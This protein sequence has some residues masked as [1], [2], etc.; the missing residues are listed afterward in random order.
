MSTGKQTTAA[1]KWWLLMRLLPRRG[2][3]GQFPPC[4][5]GLELLL[6]QFAGRAHICRLKCLCCV[7]KA[8]HRGLAKN[9]TRSFVALG[10]AN[11]YLVCH[12]LMA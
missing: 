4:F 8:C 10:L 12:S 2:G 1:H 3:G 6:Q 7:T 11:I 9:A 5:P